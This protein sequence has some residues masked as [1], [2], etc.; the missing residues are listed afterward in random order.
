VTDIIIKRLKFETNCTSHAGLAKFNEQYKD[1]V[2]ALINKYLEEKFSDLNITDSIIQNLEFQID[3]SKDDVPKTIEKQLDQQIKAFVESS[4][5]NVLSKKE[6]T[7]ENLLLYLEKGYLP[8]N[9]NSGADSVNKLVLEAAQKNTLKKIIES[10]ID[11]QISLKRL[12]DSAPLNVLDE[13]MASIVPK[14]SKKLRKWMEEFKSFWKIDSSNLELELWRSML[15]VIY[16]E[17]NNDTVIND[18]TQFFTLLLYRYADAKQSNVNSLLKEAVINEKNAR[19]HKLQY[20][21]YSKLAEAEGLLKGEDLMSS[22]ENIYSELFEVDQ[23]DVRKIEHYERL[24]LSILNL[25]TNTEFIQFEHDL[26]ALF[27]S[28]RVVY[29][30]AYDKALLEAVLLYLETRKEHETVGFEQIVGLFIQRLSQ[31]IFISKALL[32]NDF[33]VNQQKYESLK[34]F[35]IKELIQVDKSLLPELKIEKGIKKKVDFDLFGGR[36]LNLTRAGVKSHGFRSRSYLIDILEKL[37]FQEKGEDGSKVYDQYSDDELLDALWGLFLRPD[38]REQFYSFTQK[39][40]HDTYLFE[41]LQ[42][43]PVG[44]KSRFIFSFFNVSGEADFFSGADTHILFYDIS[45]IVFREIDS[46]SSYSLGKIYESV[47]DKQREISLKIGEVRAKRLTNLLHI[48]STQSQKEVLKYLQ[49]SS[50]EQT[51]LFADEL[52]DDQYATDELQLLEELISSESDAKSYG[53]LDLLVYYLKFGYFPEKHA[54][55]SMVSLQYEIMEQTKKQ[56]LLNSQI[57]NILQNKG[58]RLRFFSIDNE[59]FQEFV[60]KGIFESKFKL[61]ISKTVLLIKE[62][63][64]SIDV[65]DFSIAKT[66]I[67]EFIFSIINRD[68]E[69]IWVEVLT[70][71]EEVVSDRSDLEQETTKKHLIKL[72]GE[73]IVSEKTHSQFLYEKRKLLEFTRRFLLEKLSSPISKIVI[74]DFYSSFE[75]VPYSQSFLDEIMTWILKKMTMYSK[76]ELS[77]VKRQIE[78]FSEEYYD[79]AFNTR[80]KESIE[81]IP[82]ESIALDSENWYYL[83]KLHLAKNVA[84]TF[85]EKI[86]VAFLISNFD[87]DQALI[88]KMVEVAR[89]EYTLMAIPEFNYFGEVQQTDAPEGA[90]IRNW[91]RFFHELNEVILLVDKKQ[92]IRIRVD[93]FIKE[94]VDVIHLSDFNVNV[95]V[96]FDLFIRTLELYTP[97]SKIAEFVKQ[98]NLE[99][100]RILFEQ[101][102]SFSE[103]TFQETIDL[104]KILE[105]LRL[106]FIAEKYSALVR[107]VEM[108]KQILQVLV[109]Y[110]PAVQLGFLQ[111]LID[112]P[113]DKD[114]LH[115]V[116]QQVGKYDFLYYEKV[117]LELDETMAKHISQIE[118]EGLSREHS[119]ILAFIFLNLEFSKKDQKQ[120]IEKVKNAKPQKIDQVLVDLFK[121]VAAGDKKELRTAE[122]WKL[123]YAIFIKVAGE[124]VEISAA[125]KD[126]VV[127]TPQLFHTSVFAII[128]RLASTEIKKIGLKLTQTKLHDL[129]KQLMRIAEKKEVPIQQI[130]SGFIESYKAKWMFDFLVQNALKELLKVIDKSHHDQIKK[131]LETFAEV[132]EFADNQEKILLSLYESVLHFVKLLGENYKMKLSTYASSAPILNTLVTQFGQKSVDKTYRQ[133]TSGIVDFF[134]TNYAIQG[135]N[136]V[137]DIYKDDLQKKAYNFAIYF[138][139]QLKSEVQLLVGFSPELSEVKIIIEKTLVSLKNEPELSL[140][141]V[142]SYLARNFKLFVSGIQDKLN[143]AVEKYEDVTKIKILHVR[144]LT[145]V[146]INELEPINEREFYAKFSTLLLKSD[147]EFSEPIQT[148]PQLSNFQYALLDEIRILSESRRTIEEL[149][150]INAL[151]SSVINRDQANYLVLLT[152]FEK[153][154]SPDIEKVIYNEQSLLSS[155]LKSIVNVGLRASQAVQFTDVLVLQEFVS[156][157]TKLNKREVIDLQLYKHVESIDGYIVSTVEFV[158]S[159]RTISA[160]DTLEE[161]YNFARLKSNERIAQIAFSL[162]EDSQKKSF[163]EITK[164]MYEKQKEDLSQ[165]MDS[166]DIE[167]LK[168][169]LIQRKYDWAQEIEE[170]ERLYIENAGLIIFTQF[171]EAFFKNLGYLN[172][173]REFISYKEQER[174]VC[175]LQYLATGKEEFH[176]HLL[177][178][179]KLICG[180][181]ITNPLLTKVVPNSKE[182]EEVNKLFNAVISNWPVV[183]K[184]SQD[185]IRETFINREGVVYLKDR[186]WNIKVEHLAVDRLMTRI[187]WGFATIKL[188]WN[189]YIIFTEWI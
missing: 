10:V 57:L 18:K 20:A 158:S 84:E 170:G 47:I 100:V 83:K 51:E 155:Y 132:P 9:A 92:Q 56:P 129:G 37:E 133:V 14:F 126:K 74:V 49:T 118:K 26:R 117:K 99:I 185:A 42:H 7:A 62:L 81:Q 130:S 171:V 154:L 11:K 174:A 30:S 38:S 165:L 95:I 144:F 107:S 54:D 8:W 182:K 109:K 138:L 112:K 188:P 176:E 184:S 123:Q 68:V 113:E 77:E 86:V 52:A 94:I 72:I 159:K 172:E 119:T 147:A 168:S 148:A 175:I 178:L 75:P 110:E 29:K 33:E 66:L 125:I 48:A 25:I 134:F 88:Y 136:E 27:N 31:K 114:T 111:Y 108:R 82:E 142:R 87:R 50:S 63:K 189:K 80:I 131:K 64:K 15:W 167:Q 40:R 91:F 177:V 160:I 173:E 23:T 164:N 53:T 141:N 61:Y 157:Q 1:V 163:E 101:R 70:L 183:T 45:R 156:V 162:M 150:F 78:E 139:M 22:A 180:M 90:T 19:R 4:S 46:A 39:V 105:E 103:S 67:L 153:H 121:P 35:D 21:Y 41:L 115:D 98:Q 17:K 122:F 55:R 179:N 71:L 3:F 5:K 120:I 65:S 145:E 43:V 106:D 13:I 152:D 69:P 116:I 24:K 127:I 28:I 93:E 181:D 34:G 102:A 44:L 58:A 151:Q 186:D 73:H 6:S 161:L 32:L 12:I 16:L 36:F 97:I 104:K 79:E 187:P 140:Q 146:I 137:E 143:E 89:E 128:D 2:I 149:R 124:E 59:D 166:A 76:Y 169:D 96:I 85:F 135:K 60:L